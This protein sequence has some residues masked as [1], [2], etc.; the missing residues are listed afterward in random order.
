M[1][2]F[3]YRTDLKKAS[4]ILIGLF[5]TVFLSGHFFVFKVSQAAHQSKFRSYIQQN[6]TEL[7]KIEINPSQL[8][9]DSKG[10][11][12]FDDNREVMIGSLMYDVVYTKNSGKTISLFLVNDENEKTLMDKYSKLADSIFDDSNPAKQDV[13]KDFLSLKFLQGSPFE[14]QAPNTI[15]VN[16]Q[17]VYAASLNSGVLSKETPPPSILS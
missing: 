11:Q 17:A 13:V 7:K 10:I 6:L 8:Y 12:W 14:F 15:V 5:L 4:F 16:E 2:I 1:P 3:G 9:T